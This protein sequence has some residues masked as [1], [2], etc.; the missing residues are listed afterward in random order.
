MAKSCKTCVSRYICPNNYRPCMGHNDEETFWSLLKLP[1][2][3]CADR[4]DYARKF[5][6]ELQ[7]E[8][9]RDAKPSRQKGE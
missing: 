6:R 8:A 3:D 7:E 9:A 2:M 1:F 4:I 5:I